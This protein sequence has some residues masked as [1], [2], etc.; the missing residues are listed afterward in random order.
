MGGR[1]PAPKD[2]SERRRRNVSPELVLVT[3][4]DQVRGPALPDEYEWPEQ[5]R[6]WWETWRRSPQAQTFID[7]DWSYLL[8]TAL[9]HADL[10]LGDLSMAGELRLR[11]GKFGATP[12]DRLRLRIAVSG[13]P[14]L[15]VTP[16]RRL[17]SAQRKRLLQVAERS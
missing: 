10:W 9:L 17:T 8:D 6:Q 3:P 13:P 15:E 5:T 7:V 1:G 4:D 11:V 14:V 12:E 16:A 2:P